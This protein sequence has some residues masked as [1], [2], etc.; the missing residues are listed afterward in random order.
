MLAGY[1]LTG[2]KLRL[3]DD[4]MSAPQ[5]AAWIDMLRPTSEEDKNLETALGIDIPT[6]EEMQEIEVSSRLYTE[7]GAAF[8]TALVLSHTDGDDPIIA[9]VTFIL[10]DQRL[11]TVRYEEPRAF[12]SFAARGQ[13]AGVGGDTPDL[14]LAGLLEMI[15]ERLADV[16]ERTTRDIDRLSR[17]IFHPP[18]KTLQKPRDYQQTLNELGRKGDLAS[19]LRDSLVTLTR[20]F[21]FVVLYADQRDAEGRAR[22]IDKEARARFKSL[23]R[24]AASLTDHVSFVSQKVTF[25]LEATLGMINLEQNQIIKIFSIAAVAFLPPTLIAS[26]YGMN[27]HFMPELSW[28]HG[29]PIAVVAMLLSA[30]G[31]LIYFK[32]R[33]WW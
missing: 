3:L 22:K 21:S 13:K 18:T 31:P 12:A 23:A 4:L 16:L 25:L 8:M 7:N 24:D 29:Y 10:S 33:G 27:F 2:G 1:T 17:E 30:V 32:R 15:V 11:I 5:H 6:L 28:P 26:I 20:V 14:I 9:P 19:G